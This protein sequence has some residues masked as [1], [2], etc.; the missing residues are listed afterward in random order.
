MIPRLIFLQLA[1]YFIE[2][3]FKLRPQ[4]TKLPPYDELPSG[5][6]QLPTDLVTGRSFSSH[7]LSNGSGC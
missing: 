7:T 5:G 2:D 3:G 4:L 1:L 6:P